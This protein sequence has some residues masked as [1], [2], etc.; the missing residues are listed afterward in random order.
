MAV[1]EHLGVVIGLYHQVFC[2]ADIVV[3]TRGDSA[4][5]CGNDKGCAGTFDIESGV[6]GAVVA[7]FECRDGERPDGEREFLIYRCVRDFPW[8]RNCRWISNRDDF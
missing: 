8:T 5:I 6:V 1:A 2:L 4:G 7:R 3:G